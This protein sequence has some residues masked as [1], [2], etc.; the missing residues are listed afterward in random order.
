MRGAR[1]DCAFE[2][3]GLQFVHY[4]VIISH[5]KFMRTSIIAL[6]RK[7]Y[8]VALISLVV[9][10][11]AT[12]VIA[13]IVS[14]LSTTGTS[15]NVTITNL[16]IAKPADVDQGEVMIASIALHDGKATSVTPPS[17][18]T[19]I[20]RTDNDTNVGIVSYW[21]AAGASEPA[22]Y[23]WVL[24]PQ[25]R[26]QGGITTYS[27]V[28]TTNPIDAAA[29][30]FNRS[31]IA[32]TS[33][34]TTTSDN[35]EVI[36]LFAL[37]VGSSNFAGDFFSIPAGMME[38]YDSSKTTAGPTI[39][40]FDAVQVAAGV[41][42]SKSSTISGNPNQQRDWVSQQIAL[43]KASTNPSVLDSLPLNAHQEIGATDSFE[44]TVPTGGSNRLFVAIFAQGGNPSTEGLPTASLNG[45]SLT[46]A[47]IPGSFSRAGYSVGYLANPTSGTFTVAYT[48]RFGGHLVDYIVMTLDNASQTNP[49]DASAVSNS[50]VTSSKTTSVTTTVGNDL[51]LS[52]SF[53]GGSA[54]D[55]NIVNATYG[56][57]ESHTYLF[58][59]TAQLGPNTGSQKNAASTPGVEN[60]T[61]NWSLTGDVDEIVIAVKPA[62]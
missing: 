12:V 3:V 50:S 18:W 28:D 36:A 34:I 42:G 1:E 32:S 61:T 46:M 35:E 33:P 51:L 22:N 30:N 6:A 20:L 56:S 48:D 60:M 2:A 26:A 27:G 16:A 21:K 44:Y 37:H 11:G 45:Q 24:S 53:Y 38:K 8:V 41:A 15:A 55:N 43:R 17:G 4:W 31:K 10:F 9:L 49:V 57:G 25:T 52:M 14:G 5:Y 7:H 54:A 13:D 23:T 39:A 19:P 29:G 47:V 58:R 40:S 62:Q 59:D